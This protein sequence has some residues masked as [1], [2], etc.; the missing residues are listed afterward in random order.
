[1]KLI[2]FT[3]A[4]AILIFVKVLESFLFTTCMPMIYQIAIQKFK[5]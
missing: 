3:L 5:D 2:K 1:M 4:Y